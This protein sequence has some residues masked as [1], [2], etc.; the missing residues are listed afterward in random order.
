MHPSVSFLSGRDGRPSKAYDLEL[1]LQ[2]LAARRET[3]EKR[4]KEKH[5]LLSEFSNARKDSLSRLV[6]SFHQQNELAKQ[7][8]LELLQDVVVT[9]H[10]SS[11]KTAAVLAADLDASLN[12][13]SSS[14]ASQTTKGQLLAAKRAYLRSLENALPLAHRHEA[15]RLEEKMKR[16]KMERLQSLQRREKLRHE[17][18]REERVRYELEAQRQE[19]AQTLALEQ[20]DLLRAK[21]SSLL[22]AE[23]GRLADAQLVQRMAQ[24]GQQ[25]SASIEQRLHDKAHGGVFPHFA[26]ADVS[27]A[28][29]GGG[30]GGDGGASFADAAAERDERLV[31]LQQ[32][33]APRHAP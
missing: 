31:A 30:G 6:S 23:E 12:A 16:V 15:L 18:L 3:L 28:A 1:R 19:L 5:Q 14:V 9:I 21:A 27:L 8:N 17:L 13:S 4:S 2:D 10:Q 25:L 7:R 26:P 11:K 24:M 20:S 33:T 22:V 32:Q 29:V